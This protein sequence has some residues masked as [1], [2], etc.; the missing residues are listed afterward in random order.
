LFAYTAPAAE[1]YIRARADAAFA[2]LIWTLVPTGCY[3]GC[4]QTGTEF[5]AVSTATL[6]GARQLLPRPMAAKNWT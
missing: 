4:F 5:R 3:I 2:E 6:T 1:E